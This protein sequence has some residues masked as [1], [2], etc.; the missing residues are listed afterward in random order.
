MEAVELQ[1]TQRPPIVIDAQSIP[2]GVFADVGMLQ[3][4]L[5]I[6]SGQTG[7]RAQGGAEGST[8]TEA[9]FVNRAAD[10]RDKDMQGQVN[11]WLATAG[12]KMFQLVQQTM[13]NRIWISVKGLGDVEIRDFFQ[14]VYGMDPQLLSALPNLKESLNQQ[15]G[16][17][18][19]F[20]VSREDLEF[21]ADIQ[22]LAGSS[23]PRSLEVE[24]QEWL[25]F[26]TIF[27]QFPQLGLSRELL[28]ET[29]SKYEFVSDRMVDELFVLAQ[30]MLEAQQKTAG[31]EQ[32]GKEGEGNDDTMAQVANL[33]G[34]TAAAA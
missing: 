24:K 1:S 10:V 7:P 16:E 3:E 9:R 12:Q 20:Q 11:L 21:S 28:K 5:R 4:D 34:A 22:V 30:K 19:P 2:Q 18:K 29:A 31:R 14:Q 17:D 26:L 25:E 6:V 8:A 23:R 32:G 33:L 15:L 27:G 13:T